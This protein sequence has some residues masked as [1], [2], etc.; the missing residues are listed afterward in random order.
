MLSPALQQFYEITTI[1]SNSGDNRN[2]YSCTNRGMHMS[3]PRWDDEPRVPYAELH[4][5][6]ERMFR[7]AGI[8]AAD[9][10][11]AAD[12]LLIADMRGIETHGVQRM[13]FYLTGLENGRV[14]AGAHLSVDREQSGTVAFNGNYGLGLVMATRSMER[15]IQKA[16]E[17]GICLGTLRNSSH[18][19]IAA[20]YALMAVEHDMCG[21]S[22]TNSSALVVPTGAK[23]AALGTNP[24]AMAAPTNGDPF[25]LDMATSTVAVGK[26]EVAKRLG[27]PIPEGW[28]LDADG[29][30]TTDTDRHTALTP[31]GGDYQTGGHKGY[32][33]GMM[34]EILCSQLATSPWSDEI[35]RNHGE[36]DAGY[37][38]QAFMAWR[39]DAFRDLQDFKDA[40]TT[41]CLDLRAME[42]LDPEKPVLIPGDPEMVATRYNTEQGVPI[43]RPVYI[44]LQQLAE[45]LGVEWL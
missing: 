12:S 26:I 8:A 30:P 1:S 17:T 3:L 42:P 6:I 33:L 39:V 41:M 43:R 32:G 15:V 16:D 27:V 14:R 45:Q 11:V 36:G 37:N 24:I 21:I 7:A 25:C 13:K 34:V 38:G 23:H 44:E 22:M 5:L 18:Y 40:L 31:L 28:S 19:G 29:L 10:S 20:R 4:A 35:A 2:A 9:A